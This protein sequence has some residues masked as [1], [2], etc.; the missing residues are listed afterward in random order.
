MEPESH[1][2]NDGASLNHFKQVNN[3]G[4]GLYI[5]K[6][7]SGNIVDDEVKQNMRIFRNRDEN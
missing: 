5:R 1:P 2:E 3:K 4:P 6:T 7:H